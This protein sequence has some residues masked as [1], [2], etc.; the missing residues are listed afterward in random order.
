LQS[1]GGIGCL[2]DGVALDL[3]R[4]DQHPPDVLLVLDHEDAGLGR[5]GGWYPARL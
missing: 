4:R 5:F 3:Q 2:G 1:L